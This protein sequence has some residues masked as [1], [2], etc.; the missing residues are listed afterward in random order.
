[1]FYSFEPGVNQ[2]GAVDKQAIPRLALRV[3]SPPHRYFY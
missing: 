2:T 1:L 3:H